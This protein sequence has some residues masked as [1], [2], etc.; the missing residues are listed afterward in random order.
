LIYGQYEIVSVEP[1]DPPPDM[2]GTGWH[3]YVIGLGENTIR[4]YKQGNIKA[5]T[6]SVQEIV[7]RLNERRRGKLGR[8][9]LNMTTHG[10]KAGR[11]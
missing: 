7:A 6:G 10:K 4:G 8:V 3:C 5:V 9:H 2:Q 11:G 1:S